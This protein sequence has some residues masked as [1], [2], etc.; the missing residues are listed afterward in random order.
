MR[1]TAIV[2][3]RASQKQVDQFRDPRCEI[4]LLDSPSAEAVRD[5][6]KGRI[7]AVLVFGGD[8]TVNRHLAQLAK[9]NIPVL[10]LPA[11]SG[12]DLARTAGMP[13]FHAALNVWRRFLAGAANVL[14]VDLGSIAS[15]S[16]HEP[17]YFSCCANIGLDA[18]AARRADRMPDW[19]KSR[20]GYFLGGLMA[21]A[22]YRP[23]EIAYAADGHQ[24]SERGWFLSVSNT[25]TFGGGLKIAPQA[26]ISDSQLDVTFANAEHF[27]RAA[28]ARH[29]RKIFSGRHVG[30]AGLDVFT[31]EHLDI[32]TTSPQPIYADGEC[33]TETPCRIEVV[34]G[35]LLLVSAPVL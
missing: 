15:D 9:T 3:P 28:L 10:A 4:T 17:R 12:N 25:P 7:D 8:G 27:S 18:D 20:G 14:A 33:I 23:E 16:L 1:T 19:V 31:T 34:P 24:R 35:A 2:G 5:A 11:G 26:S 32:R 30:L 22:A 29:F 6:L 21:L 13:T